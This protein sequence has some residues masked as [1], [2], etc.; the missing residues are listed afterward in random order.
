TDRTIDG[1][2][3]QLYL[4]RNL[5]HSD[6]FDMEHFDDVVQIAMKRFPALQIVNWVPRVNRAEKNHFEQ[7]MRRMHPEYSIKDFDLHLSSRVP[8]A[9]AFYPS[10][11][12]YP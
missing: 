1:S 7:R 12:V 9:D 6:K 10:A 11:L 8:L 5:S 2:M 3:E 4:I